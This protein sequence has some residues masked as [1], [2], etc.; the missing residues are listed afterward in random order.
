MRALQPLPCHGLL[1]KKIVVVQ[2]TVV[3]RHQAV[4]D[5]VLC[6]SLTERRQGLLEKA[7]LFMRHLK[8]L[9]QK[10]NTCASC[11]LTTHS[12]L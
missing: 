3:L 9:S 11:Q 4:L 10:S 7:F 8:C 2:G 12:H 1:P 5:S 6:G